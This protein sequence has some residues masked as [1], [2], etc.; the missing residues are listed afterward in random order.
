MNWDTG[1]VLW[2][3]NVLSVS[4][5]WM[6]SPKQDIYSIPSKAQGNILEKGAEILEKLEDREK[7]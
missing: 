7:G 5:S 6:L 2:L 1:R 4:D 3:Q